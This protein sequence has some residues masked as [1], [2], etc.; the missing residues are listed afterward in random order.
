MAGFTESIPN[1]PTPGDGRVAREEPEHVADSAGTPLKATTSSPVRVWTRGKADSLSQGSTNSILDASGSIMIESGATRAPCSHP[2]SP[3][4]RHPYPRM[5]PVSFVAA[6]HTAPDRLTTG[7]SANSSTLTSPASASLS[8]RT[9]TRLTYSPPRHSTAKLI[10][11]SAISDGPSLPAKPRSTPICTVKCPPRAGVSTC[12]SSPRRTCSAYA[13]VS[14]AFDGI[15][16]LPTCVPPAVSES[17]GDIDVLIAPMASSMAVTAPSVSMALG[18]CQAFGDALYT[19]H[20]TRTSSAPGIEAA[21]V[22]STCPS[23]SCRKVLTRF[24]ALELLVRSVPGK[25]GVR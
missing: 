5:S 8:S 3:L 6:C 18:N 4:T 2:R 10:V 12:Q 13:N 11:P 16:N 21:I 24:L 19:P 14:G 17:S 1:P 15:R 7:S 9:K 22:I 20:S 23:P 25:A